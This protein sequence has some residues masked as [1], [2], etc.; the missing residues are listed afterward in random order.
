MGV[1]IFKTEQPRRRLIVKQPFFVVEKHKTGAKKG[2]VKSKR[3]AQYCEGIDT[4]F[5][6]EQKKITENPER[7]HIYIKNDYLKV[8]EEDV[9][10]LEAIR[11]HEDNVING[12]NLFREIDLEKEELFEI[13]ELEETDNVLSLLANASESTII[14]AGVWFFGMSFLERTAPS[15]KLKIREGI[16][17]SKTEVPKYK[18]RNS[19]KQF[20]KSDNND[21]KLIAVIALKEN[22]ISIRN[23]KDIVWADTKELIYSSS[24]NKFVIKE[25]VQFLTV[26]E[27]GKQILGHISD[28]IDNSLE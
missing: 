13:E 16:E 26:E 19:L 2:K 23:G 15:I 11:K 3:L 1:I 22:V 9:R 25:F 12:G 14:T 7:K 20:L 18:F 6:D 4:I 10:L 27:K 17:R 5:I 28:K 21:V 24:Q 8:D